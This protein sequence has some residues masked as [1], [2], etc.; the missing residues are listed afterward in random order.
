[1]RIKRKMDF[2]LFGDVLTDLGIIRPW[3]VDEAFA[4]QKTAE[5]HAPIGE[6]LKGLGY[7]TDEHI[8]QAL[9][10]QYSVPY[11]PVSRYEVTRETMQLVPTEIMQEH[12]LV[13]LH[14]TNNVLSVAMV[15]PLDRIALKKVE[16][17]TGCTI[18]VMITSPMEI[19]PVIK[20]YLEQTSL[21]Q[22]L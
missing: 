15:N 4:L 9:S 2:S 6:I 21:I 17:S 20:N 3:H 10:T 16:E 13:P 22:P 7:I 12:R 1:M 19:D 14:K 5:D 11:L 8:V 18:T